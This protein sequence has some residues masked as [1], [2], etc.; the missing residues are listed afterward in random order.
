MLLKQSPH[1]SGRLAGLEVKVSM[2]L[3]TVANLEDK[4]GGIHGCL[5][6]KSK[7]HRRRLNLNVL[8]LLEVL[9]R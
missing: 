9:E 2:R 4:T 7:R 8:L 6:T 5:N 1:S 3:A